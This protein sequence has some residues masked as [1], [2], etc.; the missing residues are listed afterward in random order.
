METIYITNELPDDFKSWIELYKYCKHVFDAKFNDV[1]S[2]YSHKENIRKIYNIHY[3]F[4]KEKCFDEIIGNVQFN[5]GYIKIS[6]ESSVRIFNE[7]ERKSLY[8]I[9]KLLHSLV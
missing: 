6:N 7:E 5:H 3:K 1:I 8:N 9:F 4:L 2:L